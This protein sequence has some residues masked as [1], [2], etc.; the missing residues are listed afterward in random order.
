M[1]LIE[2]YIIF[3]CFAIA[4][5]LNLWAEAR[6]NDVLR[7]YTK[8]LLIPMIAAFYLI[9]DRD[10]DWF[11]VSALVFAFIGDVLLLFYHNNTCF[12]L[13]A[14][15]F[16]L[17]H[18]F[19]I[20]SMLFSI[21][22]AALTPHDYTIPL[23]PGFLPAVVGYAIL[24]K[25]FGKFKWIAAIYML[26]ATGV[27]YCALL[28]FGFFPNY[29]VWLTILGAGFFV[30]SDFIIAWTRFKKDF[31]YSGVYIMLTYAIAEVGIVLGL[32]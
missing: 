9:M 4:L 24:A 22:F 21:P 30:I 20:H 5:F 23:I 6:D 3:G 25:L 1:F 28:R 10:T 19:F 12:R 31:K 14:I 27:L 16:M 11:I 32:M 8:P 7:Y 29:K 17:G 18:I 15:A 13:G 26:A 2:Q